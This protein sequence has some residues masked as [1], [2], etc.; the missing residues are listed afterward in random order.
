MTELIEQLDPKTAQAVESI[1]VRSTNKAK[2]WIGARNKIDATLP[3]HGKPIAYWKDR[4]KVSWKEDEELTPEIISQ[5]SQEVGIRYQEVS[6]IIAVIKVSISALESELERLT[7][8]AVVTKQSDM[9]KALEGKKVAGNMRMP[10]RDTIKSTVRQSFSD[11]TGAIEQGGA[12]LEFFENLQRSLY[13]SLEVLKNA[14]TS[15]AH[16]IKMSSL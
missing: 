4:L 15:N 12:E 3:I 6:Q 2:L 5:L 8:E 10:A 13:F 14:N 1:K 7:D 9:K 11:L 16:S